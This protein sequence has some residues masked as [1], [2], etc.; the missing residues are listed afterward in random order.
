M[1]LISSSVSLREKNMHTLLKY[2]QMSHYLCSLG[3]SFLHSVYS[4]LNTRLIAVKISNVSKIT[5]ICLTIISQNK[6]V[7]SQATGK[8]KMLL[9]PHLAGGLHGNFQL[10]CR[11][12]VAGVYGNFPA[13]HTRHDSP[14]VIVQW[15]RIWRVSMNP[16]RYACTQL[17]MMLERWQTEVVL[18]E[19]ADWARLIAVFA[20]SL[21]FNAAIGQTAGQILT[22]NIVKKRA[23]ARIAFLR[24]LQQRKINAW[25]LSVYNTA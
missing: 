14:A 13:W 12:S 3:P 8:V 22:R 1:L 9:W 20:F 4:R 16:V 19:T 5:A 7:C 11:L 10:I 2:Q 23:S 24:G 15:V 21:Y 18:V 25:N 6:H 17:C